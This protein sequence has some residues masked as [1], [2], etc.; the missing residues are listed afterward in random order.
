MRL[1][2]ALC[3]LLVCSLPLARAQDTGVPQPTPPR[4][5]YVDLGACPFEGCQYALWTARKRAVVYD[6]WKV[7]R[8]PIAH[9]AIG[10]KVQGLTGVVIT[11]QPGMIRM[12]RDLPEEH[13]KRGDKILT[14]TYGGEGTS[15]VWTNGV[16]YKDFDISFAKWPDGTGCAGNG[17]AATYVTLGKKT[18]WA[19]VRLANRRTGWVNMNDNRFDG[20]DA[21]G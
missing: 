4:L 14:Y 12:D 8:K 1:T 19:Q 7:N 11:Y 3:S 17:C 18:W 13:L 5:P 2:L 9:L 10:D 21:L 6:T 15:V 16:F 20:V